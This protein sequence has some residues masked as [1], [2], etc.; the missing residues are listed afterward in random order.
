MERRR[1][2]RVCRA[3]FAATGTRAGDLPGPA[4]PVGQAGPARGRGPRDPHGQA[5]RG[6]IDQHHEQHRRRLPADLVGR[7]AT[8][9]VR[10]AAGPEWRF[11]PLGDERG[12]IRADAGRPRGHHRK[13]SVACLVVARRLAGRLHALGLEDHPHHQRRRH[14][15]HDPRDRPL[16]GVLSGWHEDRRLSTRCPV[17]DTGPGR[18]DDEPGRLWRDRRHADAGQRPGLVTGRDSH[19]RPGR[20]RE[21][22]WDRAHTRSGA[23]P[24]TRHSGHRTAT[25]SSMAGS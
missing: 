18:G 13:P 22:G 6:G 24:C 11:G 20:D 7:R 2:G 3:V 4:G 5:R 21:R 16:P 23:G 15:R 19:C 12:R 8:D 10:P 1:D 25:R 14:R 9:C 17:A